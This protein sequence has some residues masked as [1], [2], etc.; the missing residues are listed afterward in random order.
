MSNSDEATRAADQ[1][2]TT[3]RNLAIIH[4]RA[5]NL[6]QRFWR[7]KGSAV[8]RHHQFLIQWRRIPI[9]TPRREHRTQNQRLCSGGRNR[10]GGKHPKILR[11]HK[12][13]RCARAATKIPIGHAQTTPWM[14]TTATACVTALEQAVRRRQH[15]CACGAGARRRFTADE[16]NFLAHRHCGTF[17]WRKRARAAIPRRIP[18]F[19]ADRRIFLGRRCRL[20][21][22]DAGWNCFKSARCSIRGC[23]V[24]IHFFNF[25]N[26]GI[27][28]QKLYESLCTNL[29]LVSGY[30]RTFLQLQT[31]LRFCQKNRQHVVRD[32]IICGHD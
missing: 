10:N 26:I 32:D 8:V 9:P 22:E 16:Y 19:W 5:K 21:G 25:Y 14:V 23:G 29:Q 1:A 2:P 15:S 30:M 28:Q 12:V 3:T 31:F 13:L 18:P 17:H 4:W 7:S 24:L 20:R 6:Q 27:L 11:L